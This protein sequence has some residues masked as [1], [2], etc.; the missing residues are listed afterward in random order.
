MHLT[1]RTALVLFLITLPLVALAALAPEVVHGPPYPIEAYL[2]I[3]QAYDADWLA[4]GENLVFR[5]NVTGTSQ[6]WTISA[7]GGYP[8][9]L[10]F[11]EDSINYVIASPTD[12]DLL[13]F[14]KSH[15][16][17]E[18]DQLFLTDPQGAR[19]EKITGPDDAIFYF[20][21]WSRDGKQIAYSSNSRNSSFFD[22][23]VMDLTTRESRRVIEKD[24]YLEAD[25]F[26]PSG[27]RLIVSEWESNFNNNLYL[28]DLDHP[29][30]EPVLLTEHAGWATYTHV[31]WPVGPRSAKGFFLI[32]NIRQ[33]FAKMAFFDLEK[34]T[35]QYLD[36][37]P[38][39]AERLTYSHN[40]THSAYGI[41][42]NGY[43]RIIVTDVLHEK[44]LPPP[45]L[46]Q[47]VIRNLVFSPKG[48]RYA[49]TFS[50]ADHPADIYVVESATGKARRVTFSSTG[51]VPPESFVA[52]QVVQ[53][54]T[55]DNLMIPAFVYLPRNLPP[56]G[57]AP[58][59]M[60][61]HG[62]PESQER[63]D[64]YYI[65]QYFLNR[66]YAVFAPNVRGSDG[67]GKEYLH[68]DNVEKRMD[69]VRDMAEAVDFIRKNIPQIDHQRIALFGGS[70]GGFMV[71]AGL[72]EYPDLFAAGVNV[73]GIANFE[74]FLEQ[75][76]PWRRR[77]REAEYGSLAEH[78]DLLRRISPIHKV[79]R[80]KAPL[81]V[82]HGANDPRVP[83]HE[84]EQ[85]VAALRAREM[86]VEFLQYPDEGHGLRKLKNK[87]DAYPKMADFLDRY[88]MP[89][90]P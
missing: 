79:D 12:P 73:V 78:R 71:L 81:M 60:Y 6:I 29:E 3:R 51:G 74:T 70:Y 33:N 66:G 57:K 18:R 4:D 44:I 82:I 59:L 84:A 46:S 80:I 39:D 56:G 11:F 77:I 47:G 7:D 21:A 26:S 65:Y 25:A 87:R 40:G 61:L 22:V 36:G 85:I 30:R 13:L 67:Y 24:A 89:S 52:P 14:S 19:I 38:W 90:T 8:R 62:G 17:N 28:L 35:L 41:N 48:D 31:R 86:P 54:P 64:F 75:T 16:G 34:M 2:N 53:Y 42:L 50:H 49:L 45:N 32:S 1:R 10:T 9:Q 83:L 5:T 88:L 72:T 63:P 55:S 23:Y 68:L 37:G 58:C 15:G 43:S 76:G 69:S 27:R 20:G